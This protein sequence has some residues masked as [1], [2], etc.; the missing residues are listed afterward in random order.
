[1][2]WLSISTPASSLISTTPTT[3]RP[4]LPTGASRCSSSKD[5]RIDKKGLFGG[6]FSFRRIFFVLHG[7]VRHNE[8][9]AL[10]LTESATGNRAREGA[11]AGTF[12]HP[13]I[14][15]LS[16][17]LLHSQRPSIREESFSFLL[18]ILTAIAFR[19]AIKATNRW[20]AQVAE[21]RDRDREHH[22]IDRRF[23]KMPVAIRDLSRRAG[24]CDQA[25]HQRDEGEKRGDMPGRFQAAQQAERGIGMQ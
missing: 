24:G 25:R 1:M 7:P 11:P 18:R 15:N 4:S 20:L 16:I 13:V 6:P 8:G 14:L 12:R 19:H 10:A 9:V 3:I 22:D 23:E 2:T 21:Y 17:A 5:C